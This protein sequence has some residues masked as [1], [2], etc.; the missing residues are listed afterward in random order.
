MVTEIH[1]VLQECQNHSRILV[2]MKVFLGQKYT[3]LSFKGGDALLYIFK[4]IY[5]KKWCSDITKV[6][7]Q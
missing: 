7:H 4:Y 6:Q 3:F 2:L 1:F 5:I